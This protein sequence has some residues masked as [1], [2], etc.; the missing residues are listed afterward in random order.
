[1]NLLKIGQ[2][3]YY[4]LHQFEVI[5]TQFTNAHNEYILLEDD[6]VLYFPNNGPLIEQRLLT[7]EEVSNKINEI[8]S[9]TYRNPDLKTYR[10]NNLSKVKQHMINY[11]RDNKIDKIISEPFIWQFA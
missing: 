7:I 8:E 4:I 5:S 1:M 6:E 10:L 9:T 11:L 2:R 3:Y